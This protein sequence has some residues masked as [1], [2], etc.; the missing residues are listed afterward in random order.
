MRPEDDA[1]RARTEA[2][3]RVADPDVQ[4]ELAKKA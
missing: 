2:A 1:A 4:R 3:H